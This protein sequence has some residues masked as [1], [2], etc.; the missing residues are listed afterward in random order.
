MTS[1]DPFLD[2]RRTYLEVPR[3]VRLGRRPLLQRHLYT[4][5]EV[6]DDVYASDDAMETM[7]VCSSVTLGSVDTQDMAEVDS[8]DANSD[9]GADTDTDD[10]DDRR[11]GRDEFRAEGGC[12]GR[13]ERAQ[14]CHCQCCLVAR[15][16][17]RIPIDLWVDEVHAI[18][19]PKCMST[20]SSNLCGR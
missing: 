11:R 16:L 14:D 19:A 9:V 6:H 10:D 7:S 3:T 8:S 5:H 15:L 12:V 1:I 18:L 2:L 17:F 20:P 4:I 13:C